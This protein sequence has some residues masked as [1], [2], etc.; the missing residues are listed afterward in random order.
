MIVVSRKIGA[1]RGKARLWLEGSSLEGEGWIKGRT[2]VPIFN[3]VEGKARRVA[4][5]VGRPIIDTNTDKLTEALGA[6]VGD[7]VRVEIGP[8][9]IRV[10][11][12][13]TVVYL[14]KEGGAK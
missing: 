2:F 14:A 10:T 8:D 9:R 5:A 4:G 1:N 7:V 11:Y 3:G 6:A 12:R 13:G